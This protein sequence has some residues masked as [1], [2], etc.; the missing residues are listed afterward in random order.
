MIS[1]IIGVNRDIPAPDMGTNAQTM[2]WMMDAYGNRY[3][4]SPGIVTG[5]P[6]ELEGSPGREEAT[7]RGVVFCAATAS[8][9]LG[10]DFEGARVV[11]QG[12]GNVG[13][14]TATLAA[15]EG[16][17]VVAVSDVG[18]GTFNPG[19]LDLGALEEHR[20]EAIS[21]S[22]FPGGDNVS[23]DDILE[24][25]CDVLIPAAI[26]AV[27]HGR[28]ADAVKARMIVEAANAPTTPVADL[29]L[30]ERGITVVPDILANAGGVTV[31]YLEW[32][33]NIQH[34]RW[35]LEDV[36]A[37][38]EKKMT[39]ATEQVV[40]KATNNGCSLRDAAFDVAV[41]RVAHA[42]DLRGYI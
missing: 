39:R 11:V 15:M 38:L 17:K 35:E 8:K 6:V 10:Q 29:I 3:G 12:F 32:V 25:D 33:Q 5:K 20:R 2:A 22:N 34:F 24:L 30:E 23:N 16:A 37:E 14:W 9:A 21:V 7:G 27:V 40:A 18:G 13:Y 42:A 4:Y 19:G 28:N 41:Q 36:N 1:Y 26:H 31:S